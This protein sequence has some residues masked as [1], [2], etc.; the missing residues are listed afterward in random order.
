MSDE[1]RNVK[2]GLAM[3]L[4]SLAFGVGMGISFGVNE[5]AYKADIA[6]GIVTHPELHDQQSDDKIWR[7]AQ[8]AHFHATG[9]GAFSLGLVM[10]I[11]F[12]GM[13]SFSMKLASF[14]V[15]MSGF[16]PLSW[17]TMY[18]LAPTMGRGPAHDH[19]LTEIFTYLGVGGLLLGFL[20]I[21]GSI[22]FG[23]FKYR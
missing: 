12:S 15:G 9:I 16:Y 13:S 22:F 5:S 4:L 3:V 8:R 18:T 21:V 20:M 11:M 10:L 23:L 19:I 2:L 14:L 6:V 7:F 17:Y 1:L